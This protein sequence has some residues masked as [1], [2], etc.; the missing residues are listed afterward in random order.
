[1]GGIKLVEAAEIL[2]RDKLEAVV[3]PLPGQPIPGQAD[4]EAPLPEPQPKEVRP[5]GD[6]LIESDQEAGEVA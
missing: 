5:S 4:P 3:T 1:M 6:K 2:D